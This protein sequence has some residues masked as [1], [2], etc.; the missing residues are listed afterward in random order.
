VVGK[1]RREFRIRCWRR[2]DV[3]GKAP[4]ASWKCKIGGREAGK[5]LGVG[6]ARSRIRILCWR[7]GD[8]GGKAPHAS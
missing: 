8:V 6:I 3:G 5:K 4:H 7:R 2:G 1:A